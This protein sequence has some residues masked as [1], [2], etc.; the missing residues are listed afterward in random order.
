MGIPV[1]IAGESGSGK[2]TSLRN[3]SVDEVGIFN[4]AGKPLP[5]KKQLKKVENSKYVDIYA[6]LKNPK[7]KVYVIDDSQYLMAFEMFDRAKEVGYTKFTDVALNF[8][9]LINF[10]ITQLP[11]DIIVYF[12]HHTETTETGKIK[13]KTSGKMLDNQLT[14]EGLFSI[15]LLARTDGQR[16]YFE[17]QSDGYSTAKSP[18]EMF[19]KEIDNDLKIVDTTI[20]EYWELNKKEGEK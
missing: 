20:R 11:E 7:L 9:N 16:Y 8:R 18:M 17:T 2:S 14:L 6:A 12:L 3:F 5:F 13:A 15:V 19:D 10:I 4:V 1:L